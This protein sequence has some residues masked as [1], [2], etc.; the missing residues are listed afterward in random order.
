VLTVLTVL[1]AICFLGARM[2]WHEA[3][4]ELTPQS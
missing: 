1:I 2:I 3:Q 4:L